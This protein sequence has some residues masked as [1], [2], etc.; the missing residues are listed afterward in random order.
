MN[1][2]TMGNILD[3][4]AALKKEGMT[5]EEISKLPIYLGNDDECNGIHTGWYAEMINPDDEGCKWMIEMIKEDS[6]N[7]EFKGKSILIS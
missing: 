1:Q 5:I 3:L 4:A 2:L 7:I 6:C